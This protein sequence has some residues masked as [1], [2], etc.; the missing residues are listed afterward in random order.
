MNLFSIMGA[1]T[2]IVDEPPADEN[3]TYNINLLLIFEILL[4]NTLN[5]DDDGFSFQYTTCLACL[6]I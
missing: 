6:L 5:T 4:S 1:A 2:F 3:I